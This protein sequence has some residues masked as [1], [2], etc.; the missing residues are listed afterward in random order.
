MPD[1]ESIWIEKPPVCKHLRSKQ[2][3]MDLGFHSSGMDSGVSVPCWC[4]KTQQPR[5]PDSMFA[6]QED[7]APERECFEA[8]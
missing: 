1:E 6:S 8:A 4:F 5:G 2:F 7:C 3:Y